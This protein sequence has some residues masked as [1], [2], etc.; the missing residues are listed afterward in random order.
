MKLEEKLVRI[1][2]SCTFRYCSLR[3]GE[4]YYLHFKMGI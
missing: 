3:F 2:L 1:T 4:Y